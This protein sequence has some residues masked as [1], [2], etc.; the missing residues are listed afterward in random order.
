VD[1]LTSRLRDVTLLLFALHVLMPSPASAQ[2]L[3]AKDG[4]V[5]YGHHHVTTADVAAQKRFF[6]DALGGTLIRIGTNNLEIVRF[7][8]VFIF[9]RQ[10]APSGG[11]VGTTVNHVG[12]SV[13]DLRAAVQRLKA[14]GFPL[15]TRTEVPADREVQDGILVPR[16]PGGAPVAFTMGPDGVKVELLEVKDQTLPIILREV[17]FFVPR[18]VDMQAWYIRTFD[19][20][21]RPG[22]GPPAVTLPG[23]TLIFSPSSTPVVG[24]QGRAIDHIG[25]EVRNLEGFVRELQQ[26]GVA[27]VRPYTRVEA[28]DTHVAYIQD[29][30]GTLIELVE[31]LDVIK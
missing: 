4:P 23:V 5:V 11:T 2:L 10:Q 9:F 28:L 27:L 21:P 16:A 14:N 13:P 18:N 29:P 17:H 3:A 19:A 7:P 20:V 25:F 30:W 22:G 12:F 31:G 26:K 1:I 15:I 24:T 8:N 6:V